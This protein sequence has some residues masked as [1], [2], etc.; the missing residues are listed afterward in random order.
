MK[1]LN[2]FIIFGIKYNELYETL[3]VEFYEKANIKT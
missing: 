2:H 3:S 1:L